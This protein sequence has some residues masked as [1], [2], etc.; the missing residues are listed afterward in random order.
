MFLQYPF[1]PLLTGYHDSILIEESLESY[2]AGFVRR[3]LN[4]D[5]AHTVWASAPDEEA[6]ISEAPGTALDEMVR[7]EQEYLR[8]RLRD[9]LK[10]EPTEEEL[11]EWLR[12]HTEGY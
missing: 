2:R 5:D 8:Q 1:H 9:E 7:K 3:E 11:N 4:D 10:R 12:Q 6:S